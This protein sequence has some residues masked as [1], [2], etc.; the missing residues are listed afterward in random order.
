MQRTLNYIEA[1]VGMRRAEEEGR[2]KAAE[3]GVKGKGVERVREVM[4]QETRVAR[5]KEA[6]EAWEKKYG[7]NPKWGEGRA[8]RH[9]VDEGKGLRG[10]IRK[11][12]QIKR[13]TN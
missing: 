9:D 6:D 8:R 12:L 11:V 5:M 3:G 13:A 1:E 4:G 10:S 7:G 2:N